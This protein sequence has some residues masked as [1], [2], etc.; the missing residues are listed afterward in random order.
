MQIVLR[1]VRSHPPANHPA[2]LLSE[3]KAMIGR[4]GG[5]GGVKP[6]DKADV[7]GTAALPSLFNTLTSVN[8]PIFMK[9]FIHH[10]W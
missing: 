1:S 9:I 7:L 4:R 8:Q 3:Q 2:S 6:L 10:H 5:A